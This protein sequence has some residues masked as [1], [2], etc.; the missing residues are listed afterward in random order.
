MQ[1]RNMSP[2]NTGLRQMHKVGDIRV[3]NVWWDIAQDRFF[4]SM[5][6]EDP[7]PV[8]VDKLSKDSY[9][10]GHQILST[11]VKEFD[12]SKA[13]IH[14]VSIRMFQGLLSSTDTQPPGSPIS[15]LSI[16]HRTC[17]WSSAR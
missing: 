3:P 6:R 16:L 12:I 4:C 8:D 15:C 9:K 2:I 7:Y 17:S 1:T 10:Q 5:P 13:A 14:M 11:A